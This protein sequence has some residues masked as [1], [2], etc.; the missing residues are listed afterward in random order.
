MKRYTLAY[1][2]ETRDPGHT[3][4]SCHAGEVSGTLL[5]LQGFAS[6]VRDEDLYE[7]LAD[8]AA[9]I[10]RDGVEAF[11]VRH[12]DQANLHVNMDLQVAA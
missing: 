3:V 6:V 10:E 2:V 1:D 5:D 11:T 8:A 4:W 7:S 9:V 12:V